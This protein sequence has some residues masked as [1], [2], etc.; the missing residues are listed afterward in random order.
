MAG[1]IFLFIAEPLAFL[2]SPGL[3]KH[4]CERCG[5]KLPVKVQIHADE[6]LR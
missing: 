3:K 2:E 6:R 4:D 1:S 5:L